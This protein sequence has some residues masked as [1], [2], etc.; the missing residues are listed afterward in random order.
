MKKLTLAALTLSAVSLSQTASAA[1]ETQ[2]GATVGN[3]MIT[4]SIKP[5]SLGLKNMSPSKLA[6]KRDLVVTGDNPRFTVTGQVFCKD[7]A[8]L[9]AVQAV[10]GNT[11][12]QHMDIITLQQYGQSAKDYSVAGRGAADVELQVDLNAVRRASKD[13]MQ[14]KFN[15]ANVFEQKLGSYVAKGNTAAEY[16]RETQAYDMDVKVNLVAWCKMD[17]K[18][19]SVLAGKTYAGVS[20]RKVPVT[21]LYN[22]DPAIIDGPAPRATTTTRE[23]EGGPPV[24]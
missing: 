24:K 6:S 13:I 21:I 9:T 1:D 17:P 12:V 7:G 10:L 8:K 22:G 16:L 14:L 23:A 11:F 18:A 2:L 4:K 3:V 15:P 19:N 5:G 20:G